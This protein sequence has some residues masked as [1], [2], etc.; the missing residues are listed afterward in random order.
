MTTLQQI[1]AS[2]TP[3]GPHSRLSPSVQSTARAAETAPLADA[4]ARLAALPSGVVAIVLGS[5]DRRELFGVRPFSR[6][7]AGRSEPGRPH[8]ARN[9]LLA[10]WTV[11]LAQVFARE[12]THW[13]ALGFGTNALAINVWLGT[14]EREV[15]ERL[16]AEGTA[17]QT[18]ALVFPPLTPGMDQA[19]GRLLFAR[20]GRVFYE[21][22]DN[23][24]VFEHLQARTLYLPDVEEPAFHAPIDVVPEQPLPLQSGSALVPGASSAP[25]EASDH[26]QLKVLRLVWKPYGYAP[27]KAM[28]AE[29]WSDGPL[30]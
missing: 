11:D 3:A 14:H 2:P 21:G 13:Y 23:R 9:E 20:D 26:S 22:R 1:A 8:V 18:D 17:V 28:A 12:E 10:G 27:E 6:Q 24:S 29:P 5:P 25:G 16:G 4:V 30:S 7:T 19:H 15:T